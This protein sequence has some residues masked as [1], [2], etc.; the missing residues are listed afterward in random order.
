MHLITPLKT[1]PI[2]KPKI[3]G[4]KR[5]RLLGK[6]T[7]SASRIGESWEISTREGDS[8]IIISGAFPGKTLRDAVSQFPEEILGSRLSASGFRELP[9]LVKFLDISGRISVQVHPDSATAKRFGETES[10]KME[11]WY[12]LDAQLES[13]I[14]LGCREGVTKSSF[15]TALQKGAPETCLVKMK[16]RKGDFLL[17]PPG[18]IHCAG[19]GLTIFEVSQNSDT[20]YRLHDWGR[21]EPGRKLSLEK[22]LSC[23]FGEEDKP[24]LAVTTCASRSQPQGAGA[25]L[26]CK[27]FSLEVVKLNR[28]ACE[29]KLP[30]F[31]TVTVASGSA[32]ICAG[33]AQTELSL[34]ESALLPASLARVQISADS[35]AT[36]LLCRPNTPANSNR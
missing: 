19:G 30:S 33:G 2:L 17:I 25:S 3:W 20:T 26:A 28:S 5:L 4:G 9:L 16:P 18:T 36:L 14:F 11:A 22:A 12:I 10:A 6:Q 13:F 27:E 1:A 34:G 23:V 21:E 15:L 35:S 31:A 29:V 32:Q 8:N 24:R 7:E